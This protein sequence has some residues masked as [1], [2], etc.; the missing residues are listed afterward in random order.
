MG[1]ALGETLG[2]TLVDGDSVINTHMDLMT[3]SIELVRKPRKPIVSSSCCIELDQFRFKER[4]F[5]QV[6]NVRPVGNRD[7]TNCLVIPDANIRGIVAEMDA[8]D[9]SQQPARLRT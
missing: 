3:S 8:H 6:Y 9:T 7:Q 1:S 5:G 2:T 4:T